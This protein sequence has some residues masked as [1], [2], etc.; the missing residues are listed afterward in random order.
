VMVL[1]DGQDFFLNMKDFAE[2][3]SAQ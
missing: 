1:K 3:Y 2:P